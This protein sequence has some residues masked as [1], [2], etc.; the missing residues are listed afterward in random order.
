MS[1]FQRRYDGRPFRKGRYQARRS[2]ARV[3]LVVLVNLMLIAALVA[4]VTYTWRWL[5]RPDAF[6][7]LHIQMSAVRYSDQASL[8]QDVHRAALR[9]FFTI[10]TNQL[11]RRI[12]QYPW[13]KTVQV[14]RIFP[15]RLVVNVQEYVPI[16]V[17]NDK[18]VYTQS[19]DVIIP[20]AGQTDQLNV[21]RL[22]VPLAS[23]LPGALRFYQLAEQQLTPLGLHV[24]QVT[25]TPRNAWEL[26]LAG[27]VRVMLGREQV[28][29]R[30]A[31]LV[32][33][34]SH[35]VEGR[36]AEV[37]AIDLRYANGIAVQWREQKG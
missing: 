20:Q 13:V 30:L 10:Q 37:G 17:W 6:P 32:R 9:G 24:N 5:R 16:A 14:R 19:K 15:D 18:A 2:V 34:Y 29:R 21:V 33:T 25:Q 7:F 28:G 36:A 23:E 22:Y 27:G 4:G 11:K 8:R 35:I 26:G 12:L 1:V 3:L 31:R